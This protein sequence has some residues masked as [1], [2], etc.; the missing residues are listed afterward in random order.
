MLFKIYGMV[1]ARG[2]TIRPLTAGA[3]PAVAMKRWASKEG[4]MLDE[5]LEEILTHCS[6]CLGSG[7]KCDEEGQHNVDETEPCTDCKGTGKELSYS[8]HGFRNLIL[9][10]EL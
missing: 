5:L 6:R 9:N 7:L 10:G 8:G 2:F 1:R 4:N 3:V